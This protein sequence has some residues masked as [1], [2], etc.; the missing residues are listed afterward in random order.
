MAW[1][2]CIVQKKHFTL[3][4]KDGTTPTAQTWTFPMWGTVSYTVNGLTKHR[5]TLPTGLDATSTY[6]V[7]LGEEQGMEIT[8]SDCEQVNVGHTSSGD[9]A[10]LT[11][12]DFL[13]EASGTTWDDI[14]ST[15]GQTG[16][17]YLQAKT[18]HVEILYDTT[19]YTQ[20][21]HCTKTGTLTSNPGANMINYTFSS[22]AS[23][24]V[25]GP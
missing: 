20:F 18:F 9:I 25:Q 23:L 15:S 16:S 1:T 22:G 24:P 7:G 3:R 12:K 21:P 11:L 2:T 17:P 8:L 10:N 19:K 13:D 5:Y 4:I 6:G 14:V